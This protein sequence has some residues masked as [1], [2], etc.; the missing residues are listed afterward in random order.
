MRT[1]R[2]HPFDAACVAVVVGGAVV[3]AVLAYESTTAKGM[4]YKPGVERPYRYI[5]PEPVW[6][7]PEH[8]VGAWLIGLPAGFLAGAFYWLLV[9]RSDANPPSANSRVADHYGIHAKR[10]G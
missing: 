10:V 5:P 9:G 1:V 8:W 3:L 2:F 4:R 6:S 7:S